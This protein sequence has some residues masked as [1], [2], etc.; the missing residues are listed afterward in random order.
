MIADL[1]LEAVENSVEAGAGKVTVSVSLKDGKWFSVIEDDGF[2]DSQVRPF[3]GDTSKGEGRGKGLIRILQGSEHCSLDSG[4]DGTV[5]SFQV[6]DDRSLDDLFSASLP[7]LLWPSHVRLVIERGGKETVLDTEDLLARE[8]FPQDARGI[9]RFK[10]LL[11][12]M[13]A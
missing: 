7:L 13:E 11:R 5:L 10:E 8:A 6:P 2:W 1:L 9:A 3:S 12:A 4:P